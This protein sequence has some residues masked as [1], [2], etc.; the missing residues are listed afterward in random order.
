M[1]TKYRLQLPNGIQALSAEYKDSNKYLVIDLYEDTIELQSCSIVD[2]RKQR[3]LEYKSFESLCKDFDIVESTD[4]WKT[5]LNDSLSKYLMKD[6][7]VSETTN[8]YTDFE[9]ED[10]EAEQS[11]EEV[12]TNKKD[13]E[14]KTIVKTVDKG[15]GKHKT[16]VPPL[17]LH[18]L[19]I[20]KIGVII[21]ENIKEY[22][23]SVSKN[24]Q[25]ALQNSVL[26]VNILE[27][28][29]QVDG[30]DFKIINS[31]ALYTDKD[32]INEVFRGDDTLIKYNKA[33][34][35]KNIILE[36]C[37]GSGKTFKARKFAQ[38]LVGNKESN[39]I[40]HIVMSSDIDYGTLVV[41]KDIQGNIHKGLLTEFFDFASKYN[42][43]FVLI[44]E[45][46]GRGNIQD[47]FGPYFNLMENKYRGTKITVPEL[48]DVTIP[49][50]VIII[51]TTNKDSSDSTSNRV[52]D[53]FNRRCAIIVED[54]EIGNKTLLEWLHTKGKI[55]E[56]NSKIYE[57]IIN[58]VGA[59]NKELKNNG[60]GAESL[61][62]HDF[63][64][65][66]DILSELEFSVLPNIYTKQNR[67]RNVKIDKNVRE[68]ER[69]IQRDVEGF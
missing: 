23:E 7:K 57:I 69:I 9:I 51:M 39:R 66:E 60:V 27:N 21:D 52:S 37:P 61:I 55:T 58:E 38:V 22:G 6:S 29:K 24:I 25:N 5:E 3:T 2:G 46:I 10:N 40:L 18:D 54:S 1:N 12:D 53:A 45:E 30:N 19:T 64:F 43:Q 31:D 28:E 56:Q 8:E 47:A 17:H 59:I 48:G 49:E 26:N 42:E 50:N 35:K 13:I 67:Y 14:E 68:L 34:K 36:G 63:I 33:L 20:A 16:V 41:Y 4:L 32:F 62:G 15:E 11:K 44:I 65:S